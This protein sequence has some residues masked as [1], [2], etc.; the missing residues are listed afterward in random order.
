LRVE[1]DAP[2]PPELL[3]ELREWRDD[4]ARMLAAQDRPSEAGGLVGDDDDPERQAMTEHYSAPPSPRPYRPSDPDPLRD[5]LLAGF[6]LRPP[7]PGY[8]IEK[9]QT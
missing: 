8:D 3:A 4:I 5:G 6:R 1:G 7:P 9:R 2:P